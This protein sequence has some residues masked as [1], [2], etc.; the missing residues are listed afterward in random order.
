MSN[1]LFINHDSFPKEIGGIKRVSLILAEEL[2]KRG[3]GCYFMHVT[4]RS[5]DLKELNYPSIVIPEIRG[6]QYDTFTINKVTEYIKLHSIDVVLNQ[7]CDITSITDLIGKVRDSVTIKV[8]STLHFSPIHDL[9]V[10]DALFFNSYRL[11]VNP[12]A[13]MKDFFSWSKYYL[14]KQKELRTSLKLKY[15]RIASCS[16]KVVLLS[17]NYITLFRSIAPSVAAEKVIAINNPMRKFLTNIGSKEKRIVWVGRVGFDM[18]R[19]DYMMRIWEKIYKQLPD[20][21]LSILGGGP[22]DFFK[23]IA[24]KKGLRNI[25]F[26]GFTDPFPY[27]AKASIICSTSVTEGLPM[28]LLEGM[29]HGCVPISFDSFGSIHDII[30]NNED[31]LIIKDFDMSNYAIQIVQL[32]SDINLLNN[33]SQKAIYK[34]QQF[35]PGKIASQWIELFTE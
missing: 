29:A 27:Y 1:I 31:G 16:D 7:H 24:R 18:K 14:I 9:S 25:E 5:D 12:V 15:E 4:N 20:W 35:L 26:L 17:E 22:L 32:A 30:T 8:L 11:G 13:W 6:S 23:N 34:T 2:T 19:V 3:Y 10:T 21:K 28:N 33:L